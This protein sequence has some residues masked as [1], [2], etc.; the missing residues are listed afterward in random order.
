[1]IDEDFRTLLHDRLGPALDQ[2]SAPDVLSGVRARQVRHQRSV[3]AGLAAAS[4]ATVAAVVVAVAVWPGGSSAGPAAPTPAAPSLSASGAPSVVPSPSTAIVDLS[5]VAPLVTSGPCA[6]LTVGAF[7]ESRDIHPVVT[8][9]TASGASFSMGSGQLLDL[10]ST[11]PCVDRLSFM[12]RTATFQESVD[13][14]YSFLDGEAA[15]SPR[16]RPATRPASCSSSWTA[17]AWSAPAP[18]RHWPP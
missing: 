18:A 3:R 9:L 16:G 6:G 12:P 4:A 15:L 10:R 14:P 7:V 5:A 2:L 8:A 11:G 17:R 13:V 1:M